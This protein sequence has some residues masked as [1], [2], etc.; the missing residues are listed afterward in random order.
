[1]ADAPSRVPGVRQKRSGNKYRNQPVEIDGVRFP[2]KKEA[3]RWG[4]LKL[5]ERAGEIRNL[6]RQVR[7]KI[8]VN[9]ELVATYVSDAEY[10][11]RIGPNKWAHVVEDVKSEATRKNQVFRIKERLMRAVHGIVIRI[12]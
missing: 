6:R 5:L 4:E 10:E 7:H 2:S 3:R 9:G 11:E 8:V 12:V 1:M